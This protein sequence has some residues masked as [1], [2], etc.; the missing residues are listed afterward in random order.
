VRCTA[1]SVAELLVSRSRNPECDAARAFLAK[2]IMG[3]LTTLDGKT[4]K[5]ARLSILSGRQASP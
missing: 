4:G 1:Y 5:R 3:K 2:G